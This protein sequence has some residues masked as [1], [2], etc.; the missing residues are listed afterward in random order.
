MQQRAGSRRAGNLLGLS[1]V[2]CYHRNLDAL[3]V[4]RFSTESD[5]IRPRCIVSRLCTSRREKGREEEEKGE[6]GK[7]ERERERERRKGKRERGE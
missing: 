4:V 3:P 6:K 5:G 1:K 7:R 2:V